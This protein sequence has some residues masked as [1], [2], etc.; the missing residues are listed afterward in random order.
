MALGAACRGRNRA[1][2]A[3]A[4]LAPLFLTAARAYVD[5][6]DA[7]Y[8]IPFDDCQPIPGVRKSKVGA[9]VDSVLALC[10]KSSTSLTTTFDNANKLFIG[11]MSNVATFGA[12]CVPI[13]ET[14]LVSDDGYTIYPA[15]LP[16]FFIR[17]GWTLPLWGPA[18]D[19]TVM[20]ETVQMTLS[21][22]GNTDLSV[23]GL[24]FADFGL[25]SDFAV[26]P[27]QEY[28]LEFNRTQV[29]LDFQTLPLLQTYLSGMNTPDLDPGNVT[30]MVI[31]RLYPDDPTGLVGRAAYVFLLPTDNV[32]NPYEFYLFEANY[33][34]PPPSATGRRRLLATVPKTSSPPSGSQK[35][36]CNKAK[37]P[38][39][40][41]PGAPTWPAC[42]KPPCKTPC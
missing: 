25:P 30:A 32:M 4:L 19:P 20:N 21:N 5:M 11:N 14:L 1:V 24:N 31:V 33:Y 13:K 41:K 38:P 23:E 34:L 29:N 27:G 16:S 42:S 15:P 37:I 18:P 17:Q 10:L 3:L 12:L 28:K 39:S 7:R 36:C 2:A 9:G 40:C 22:N 26:A 6:K 8:S 35:G